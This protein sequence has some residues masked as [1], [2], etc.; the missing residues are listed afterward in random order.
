MLARRA[1][2]RQDR[3]RSAIAGNGDLLHVLLDAAVQRKADLGAMRAQLVQQPGQRGLGLGHDPQ[4]QEGFDDVAR[5]P[6]PGKA[7]VIVLVAPDPFGQRRRRRRRDRPTGRIKQQLQRQRLPQQEIAVGQVRRNQRAPVAPFLVGQI[8]AGVDIGQRR[9]DHRLV[10][11]GDDGDDLGLA[12]GQGQLRLDPVVAAMVDLQLFAMQEQAQHRSDMERL[13]RAALGHIGAALA[14]TVPQLQDDVEPHPPFQ[15]LDAPCQFRPG[16]A[17]RGGTVQA[18][19]QHR[20]AVIGLKPRFQHVAVGAIAS[21]GGER[22]L[23]GDRE[24][25]A[26][27]AILQRV[28]T[29]QQTVE[30]RRAVHVR[31]APPVDAPVRAR[32]CHATAVAK[33]CIVRQRQIARSVARHQAPCPRLIDSPPSMKK[34]CPVT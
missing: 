13:V 16:Q 8:D 18:F 27:C 20:H 23:R 9:H 14:R 12:F 5:I 11:A 34:L 6:H 24:M 21:G 25:A 33:G 30:Q 29:G 15:H 1:V 17:P 7:I 32:Q 19:G 4:M 2:S 26:L 28:V 22:P 10:R 31:H 3:A